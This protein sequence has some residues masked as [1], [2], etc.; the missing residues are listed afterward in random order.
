MT[1][2]KEVSS[3]FLINVLYL[4]FLSGSAAAIVDVKTVLALKKKKKNCVF[5]SNL[6]KSRH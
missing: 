2:D 5:V 3:M 1:E 6:G 4:K